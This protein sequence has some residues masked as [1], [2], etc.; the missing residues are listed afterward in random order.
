MSK[1]Y[2]FYT[3][4][5]T[6]LALMTTVVLVIGTTCLENNTNDLIAQLNNNPLIVLFVGLFL[7]GIMFYEFYN[8]NKRTFEVREKGNN[9]ITIKE[10][11]LKYTMLIGI[12]FIIALIVTIL[13]FI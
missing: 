1:K 7:I 6:I 4:I 11:M 8:N 2:I 9:P 3:I 5:D 10:I 13:L 12:F